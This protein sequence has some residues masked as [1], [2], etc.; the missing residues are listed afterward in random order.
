MKNRVP[1]REY[2]DWDH[3]KHIV[4]KDAT[5]LVENYG[6]LYAAIRKFLADP[7][8]KSAERRTLV[9]TYI[10]KPVGQSARAVADAVLEFARDIGAQ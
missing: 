7:T 8:H 3:F 4:E 6:Q 2:Y 10:G 9:R 5:I 1:C